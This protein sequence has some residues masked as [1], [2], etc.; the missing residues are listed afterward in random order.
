MSYAVERDAWDLHLGK[1]RFCGDGRANRHS[2]IYN[3]IKRQ[4]EDF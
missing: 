4:N 2:N 1:Y 3:E